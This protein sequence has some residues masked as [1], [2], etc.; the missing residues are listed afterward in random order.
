MKNNDSQ[1]SRNNQVKKRFSSRRAQLVFVVICILLVIGVYFAS[2]IIQDQSNQKDA[3][4]EVKKSSKPPSYSFRIVRKSKT[5]NHAMEGTRV[6]FVIKSRSAQKIKN[7]QIAFD[8][9]YQNATKTTIKGKGT[10]TILTAKACCNAET[11]N[12]KVRATNSKGKRFAIKYYKGSTSLNFQVKAFSENAE[13]SSVRNYGAKGDGIT[14]DTD[15]LQRAIDSTKGIL[16][17]PPGRYKI[18]KPL[19]MKSF[20]RMKGTPG[21]TVFVQG[22]TDNPYPS[23]MVLGDTFPSAYYSNRPQREQFTNFETVESSWSK[24]TDTLT[25]KNSSDASRLEKGEIVCVRSTKRFDQPE[26]NLSHPD[27]VQFTRI[28]DIDGKRLQFAE[29]AINSVGDQNNGPPQVCKITGRDPYLSYIMGRDINWYAVKWAEV[30]GITFEGGASGFYSGFCYGCYIH[31][32]KFRGVDAPM[33]LNTMVKTNFE[34]IEGDYSY[35]AIEVAM[36]SS[37]TT[38]N[39]INFTYRPLSCSYAS[40]PDPLKCSPPVPS[41]KRPPNCSEATYPNPRDCPLVGNPAIAV[42]ERSVDITFD[43]IKLKVGSNATL[44]ARLIGIGDAQ[45]INFINSDLSIDGAGNQQIFEFRGNSNSAGTS[46]PEKSD[47]ET[48]N[49]IIANNKINLGIQKNELAIIVGNEKNWIQDLRF[50][51]N[52]WTGTPTTDGTAYWAGNY[53]RD[54]SVVNESLPIATHFR[55]THDATHFNEDP[56][57][58][59]VVFG[60]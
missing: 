46:S 38:Y 9:K 54:W 27:F 2:R 35:E 12:V 50:Y 51:N 57:I 43:K 6:K 42:G 16:Y 45:D 33:V 21:Q 19:F 10:H 37:Q 28:K 39:N 5:I 30:S 52:R 23:H 29:R 47:F 17:V 1:N 53:V 34:N 14:D 18:T 4:A 22:N 59:N 3:T 25:L 56:T 55:V 44:P 32:V 41:N 15:A 11:R 36:A 49:Y 60:D 40:E 26:N 7:I 13:V 8:G 48:K 58:Y 31:D 20:V 24:G